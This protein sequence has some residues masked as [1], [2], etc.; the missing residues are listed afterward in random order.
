MTRSRS[1][2]QAEAPGAEAG[3]RVQL[4]DTVRALAGQEVPVGEVSPAK[5]QLVTERLSRD[6]YD[7]AEVRQVIAERLLVDLGITFKE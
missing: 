5:L 3:D 1:A 6:F 7:E 4:S 2:K